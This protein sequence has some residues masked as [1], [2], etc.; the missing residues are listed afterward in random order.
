MTFILSYVR[1][2]ST[3][4]M[5]VQ[6]CVTNAAL[7]ES[8]HDH[9]LREK[10]RER[11]NKQ[12]T[13]FE[14]IWFNSIIKIYELNIVDRYIDR[15]LHWSHEKEKGHNDLES[16]DLLWMKSQIDSMQNSTDTKVILRYG[17]KRAAAVKEQRR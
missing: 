9:V 3:K 13:N 6:Y 12:L 14:I 10:E 1:S 7:N 17:G 4:Y 2:R 15:S 16:S 5:P 8:I 11:E